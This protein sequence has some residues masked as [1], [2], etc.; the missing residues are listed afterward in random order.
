LALEVRER[1]DD[2]RRFIGSVA[3]ADRDLLED[4]CLDETLDRVVGGLERAADQG[5]RSLGCEDWAPGKP[6]EQ[7]VSCGIGADT[8]ETPAPLFLQG[9]R[10][11]LERARVGD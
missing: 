1:F 10:V 6:V 3:A 8:A 5:C 11:R 2:L 4:A 9:C 7:K